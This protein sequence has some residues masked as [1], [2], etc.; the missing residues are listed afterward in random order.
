MKK[1]GG[2][3]ERKLAQNGFC[4][5]KNK[6][7]MMITLNHQHKKKSWENFCNSLKRNALILSVVGII[8][9]IF[10]IMLE[11]NS[12]H[13]LKKI[14]WKG[15][16]R[17]STP[18]F[19]HRMAW[20]TDLGDLGVACQSDC[21]VERSRRRRRRRRRSSSSSSSKLYF[22]SDWRVA[23][24][25]L[26]LREIDKYMYNSKKKKLRIFYLEFWKPGRLKS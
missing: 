4:S 16:Q 7:E 10:I 5:D 21:S 6:S 1:D 17:I 12:R 14:T 23:H 11:Y 13:L 26:Y 2:K 19:E 3:C 25:R 22:N 18:M 9:F 20:H 24:K 8:I 15:R